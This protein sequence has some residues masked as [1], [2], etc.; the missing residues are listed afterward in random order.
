VLGDGGCLV[1]KYTYSKYSHQIEN[2]YGS[3]TAC[4][5][6]YMTWL[7]DII[8]NIVGNAAVLYTTDGAGSSYLKCGKIEGV[9]ATVDFGTGKKLYPRVLC[10][11]F[12]KCLVFLFCTKTMLDCCS[13]N[14]TDVLEPKIRNKIGH[15][16]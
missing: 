11:V 15:L 5:K 4:D 2:E 9:Y 16:S 12:C 8:K 10:F 7:R 14:E 1:E 6:N 3:Y 13:V